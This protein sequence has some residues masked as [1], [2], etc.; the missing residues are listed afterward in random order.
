M[1]ILQFSQRVTQK[2]K[3]S[4]CSSSPNILNLNTIEIPQTVLLLRG[5]FFI[6]VHICLSHYNKFTSPNIGMISIMINR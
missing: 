4:D 2:L 5:T 3:I 6:C 1:I